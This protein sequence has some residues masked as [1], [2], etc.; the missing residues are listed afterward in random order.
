MSKRLNIGLL[1]DDLDNYFAFKA[2][3]GSELAAKVLD[4]NLF[5]FPG[6]YLGEFKEYEYQYNS[7][8]T[9]PDKDNVDI[10][11]VLLGT[12]A[13]RTDEASKIEFLKRYE[14]IPVVTLFMQQEGYQSV[15]FDNRKGMSEV[16]EHMLDIH[17]VKK[18]G[19]V[20][21]PRTSQ[22]S[23]E[24]LDAFLKTT[25]EAGIEVSDKQIVYGDFLENSED[26]VNELLSKN[27]DLE[28]IL[29]ANDR[30]VI[31]AYNVFKERGIAPGK[32]I[33]VTGFDDD[34]FSSTLDPS[35]TTVEANSEELTY[36]AVLKTLEFIEESSDA[37]FRAETFL[38]QRDSCGCF[39]VDFATMRK[40]FHL[41]TVDTNLKKTQKSIEK[42]LFGVF[43]NEGVVAVLKRKFSKF[44]EQYFSLINDFSTENIRTV[45]ALLT[46]MINNSII[47][48]VN[49][50][51][52]FYILQVLQIEGGTR[53][54]DQMNIVSISE[55]FSNFFRRLSFSV[56]AVSKLS[57]N[58][59]ENVSRMINVHM[60]NI[61]FS[62]GQGG[63][64]YNSLL[65]GLS[66]IGVKNAYIYMIQGD[67]ETVP[68]EQWVCP[69]TMLLKAKSDGSEVYELPEEQQLIRSSQ[70]LTNEY[71]DNSKRHTLTVLPLFVGSDLFGMFV[72]NCDSEDLRDMSLVTYQMSV[73]IKSLLMI[74]RQNDIKEKLQLSLDK[75]IKDNSTLSAISKSDELTGLYNR[76]GFLEFATNAIQDVSNKGKKAII[77][78]ADMDN[79]KMVND[80]FGHD[81]GDFSL[82][83]IAS[84]LRENFRNT[85]IVGRF[86]G[87][88]FVA[89]AITGQADM[90]PIIK[91]RLTDIVRKHNLTA[92]K[93]YPIDM[94]VGIKEFE[95]DANID[96][97]K[98]LDMADEKLYE[99]KNAKKKAAGGSYR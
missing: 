45:D 38:C 65:G 24:R 64:P 54:T 82:R 79:L 35:L 66:S 83:E 53:I 40:K 42:Y 26:A 51:R 14:G 88:E 33:L 17:H 31:G 21:G 57:E 41:D 68:G 75:Y 3:V 99:E 91:A 73:T 16:V 49:A 48:Y 4:A 6:R 43:D 76:R 89:F 74:Q 12:I 22:E 69:K 2:C 92:D 86:G 11:F 97:F 58:R 94:S 71:I 28:A 77:C 18:F 70:L 23:N 10:I 19:F 46:E 93:P 27:D 84:I 85:D 37:S 25:A 29:F 72:I 81:E 7:V 9:L 90:E 32:D 52:I 1:I 63:I 62:D 98:I 59:I 20:C 36:K 95:C 61:F 44:V 39:G 56:S 80:K 50:E 5:I 87:D 30:M 67:T 15:M 13:C 60:G 8:F 78:Y 55:M 96:I 47:K 34:S